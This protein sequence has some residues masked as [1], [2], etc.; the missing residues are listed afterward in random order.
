M[1]YIVQNDM[2][3]QIKP[4]K[5]AALKAN[6]CAGEFSD[7]TTSNP[8]NAAET[9]TGVCGPTPRMLRPRG[10]SSHYD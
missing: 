3:F 8:L 1:R 9:T 6:S 4:Q 2:K 5:S 10:F 7:K